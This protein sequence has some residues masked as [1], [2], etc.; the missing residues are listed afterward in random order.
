MPLVDGSIVPV[1]CNSGITKSLIKPNGSGYFLRSRTKLSG[2][3][4]QTVYGLG[5]G[6][7]GESD[8]LL[9]ERVQYSGSGALRAVDVLDLVNL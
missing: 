6:D 1:L 8:G 5:L 2:F 7:L 4:P 3:N 9:R